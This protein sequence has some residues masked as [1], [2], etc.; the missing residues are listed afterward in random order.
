MAPHSISPPNG[1]A[2]EHNESHEKQAGL[3]PL[4]KGI[5]QPNTPSTNYEYSS[6]LEA[7][8]QPK[9]KAAAPLRTIFPP[10]QIEE[11][12]IDDIPSLK[13]VVVGAGIA[14]IT[15]GILLPR[16]VPGLELKIFEKTSDI[17]SYKYIT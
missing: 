10:L 9:T 3:K 1:I 5:H 4:I 11:H 12:A 13:A 16:K 7:E 2:E 6:F 8:L 14:G 15:T 17:V